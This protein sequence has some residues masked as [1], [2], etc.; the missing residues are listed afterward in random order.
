MLGQF[1]RN[2][3]SPDNG[4]ERIRLSSQGRMYNGAAFRTCPDKIAR[5][6][7]RPTVVEGEIRSAR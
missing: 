4:G 3:Q 1:I 5:Y 7:R 6:N 2:H